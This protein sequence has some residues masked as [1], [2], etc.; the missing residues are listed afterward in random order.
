MLHLSGGVHVDPAVEVVV[1][2]AWPRPTVRMAST[3]RA[4]GLGRTVH[5]A[6]ANRAHGLGLGAGGG[7]SAGKERVTE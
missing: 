1:P 3:N 7:C 4:H 6:S 2:C 5:V